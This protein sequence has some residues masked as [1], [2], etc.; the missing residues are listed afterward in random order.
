MCAGSVQIEVGVQSGARIGGFQQEPP[1]VAEERQGLDEAG[2]PG[3]K[4]PDGHVLVGRTRQRRTTRTA[5]PVGGGRGGRARRHTYSGERSSPASC[6]ISS[7]EDHCNDPLL[8][9]TTFLLTL[10]ATF[11][12]LVP[13]GCW[14]TLSIFRLSSYVLSFSVRFLILLVYLLP[15]FI[16]PVFYSFLFNLLHTHIYYSYPI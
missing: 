15:P 10:L 16:F 11:A 7:I 3:H 6:Q 4:E 5:R 12:S 14:C 13:P 2:Y 8:Y 1:R 9:S